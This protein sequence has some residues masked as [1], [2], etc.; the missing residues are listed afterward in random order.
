LRA[1]PGRLQHTRGRSS[2]PLDGSAP[3]R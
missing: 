2:H 1:G 3:W